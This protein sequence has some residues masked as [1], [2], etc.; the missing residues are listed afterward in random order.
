MSQ[1]K[2]KLDLPVSKR[3]FKIDVFSVLKFQQQG[4]LVTFYHEIVRIN[5]LSNKLEF[6]V[7]KFANIVFFSKLL[8]FNTQCNMKRKPRVGFLAV[9]TPI[10]K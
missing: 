8:D 10:S 4:L 6:G 9:Y 7:A 1:K 3:I 2:I 5:S